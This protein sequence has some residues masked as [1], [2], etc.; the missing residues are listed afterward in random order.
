MVLTGVGGGDVLAHAPKGTCGDDKAPT[1]NRPCTNHARR[2]YEHQL[3]Y[4]LELPGSPPRPRRWSKRDTAAADLS[5]HRFLYFHNGGGGAWLMRKG[6][7]GNAAYSFLPPAADGQP[8][9]RFLRSQL[10]AVVELGADLGKK[11]GRNVAN[12]VVVDL[13]GIPSSRPVRG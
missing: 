13:N 8:G 5:P 7:P 3:G 4:P 10:R 11:S 1:I 2:G 12:A 6:G 9:A